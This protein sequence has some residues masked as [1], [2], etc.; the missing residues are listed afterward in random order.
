MRAGFPVPIE[1]C[2]LRESMPNR[3]YLEIGG[4]AP[5]LIPNP[6]PLQD[7]WHEACTDVTF[8]SA[9]VNRIFTLTSQDNSNKDTRMGF[10]HLD[11][12]HHT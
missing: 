12:R 9:I 10:G 7:R 1:M 6:Q 2:K 4:L 8:L 11:Q 5:M 3:P